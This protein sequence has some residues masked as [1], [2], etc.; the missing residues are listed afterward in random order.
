MAHVPQDLLDRINALEREVRQIRGRAEMRPAMNRI[1]NGEVS[2]G[3][4]GSFAVYPP[5]QTAAVFA[6]GQWSGDEFGTALRRQTGEIAISTVNGDGQADSLQPLRLI[7]AYGNVTYADDIA[8]F[9]L[10]RPYIQVPMT[11]GRDFEGTSWQTTHVGRWVVQ[12]P[13]LYAPY[14]V[15]TGTGTVE[16]RLE[17]ADESDGLSPIPGSTISSSNGNETFANITVTPADHGL[18]YGSV[19]QV[20]LRARR[21]AGSGAGTLWCRGFYGRQT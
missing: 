18:A 20:Y 11:A 16:A 10:A 7:D 4:G 6:V 3:E 15:Y 19:R 21:T 8:N 12:N 13:V 14:S 9:G 1:V 17:I 5:G 2:I